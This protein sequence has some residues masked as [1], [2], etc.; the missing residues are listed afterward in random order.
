[1]DKTM[2]EVLKMHPLRLKD[3]MPYSP[4][5]KQLSRKCLKGDSIDEI[6]ESLS[7]TMLWGIDNKDNKFCILWDIRHEKDRAFPEALVRIIPYNNVRV[8]RK[9]HIEIKTTGDEETENLGLHFF[10]NVRAFQGKISN[11][12]IPTD[13]T[14]IFN[15]YDF[16]ADLIE[17]NY[18]TFSGEQNYADKTEL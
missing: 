1:M 11:R 10:D 3:N 6:V 13:K 18:E 14:L 16:K 17:Q 5:W 9:G 7:R 15:F 2:H 4:Y 12:D 8:I